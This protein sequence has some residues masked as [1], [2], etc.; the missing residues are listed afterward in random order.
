MK[1]IA[2]EI[3]ENSEGEFNYEIYSCAEDIED[4]EDSLDGGCCTSTIENALGMATDQAQRL[5]TRKT[6]EFK[7]LV[8]EL[9]SKEVK[10]EAENEE[11]AVEII[12]KKYRNQDIVL[13]SGDFAHE[14]I[15]IYKE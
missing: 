9:L 12:K 10:V 11:Q 5:L 3:Y 6:K 4:G 2:I 15:K 1:T 14:T 7:V 13:D 8:E